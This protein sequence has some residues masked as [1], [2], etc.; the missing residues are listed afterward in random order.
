MQKN[1]YLTAKE[2]HNKMQD[3]STDYFLIDLKKDRED[4][5]N[6]K[7]KELAENWLCIPGIFLNLVMEGKLDQ[8]W[9][10]TESLPEKNILR[11]GLE[12]VHP[13]ITMKR[14]FENLEYLKSIN[15][16]LSNV[17]LTCTRPSLLNGLND[18]SRIGPF[19]NRKKD[20]FLE[21][22]KY[23]YGSDCSIF[24]H[25]LCLAE[26]NYQQNNLVEAELL[27]S[28]TIK[29]FDKKSK[30]R[31]LFAALFLQSKIMLASNPHIKTES[32]IQNIENNIKK[33]GKR[34]FYY[35]LDAVKTLFSMYGG[36]QKFIFDWLKN[37]SP[38]EYSDFNMLDL[39]R[40]MIK[41]RCYIIC[42]N[43][44]AAMALADKLKDL[45]IRGKRFMDLCEL[46]LLLAMSLHAAK[47]TELAF[48]TLEEA[49]KLAKRHKYY[50]M[51]ADE[52]ERML[53]L[54]L[55]YI[56]ENG[57]TPFLKYII[58]LTRNMAIQHPLYL[59]ERSSRTAKFSETEI[60][61][62]KLLEQGKNKEEIS[63]YFMISVNTVKY[64]LKKIYAKLNAKYPHQAVWNAK[65]S[66]II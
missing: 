14:L 5:Y 55:A 49:L 7:N 42:G 34:E 60:N 27:V 38:D 19:L 46:N 31:L 64:H 3:F 4:F 62:L 58:E 18:F 21:Y 61:I 26:Y 56:K 9:K 36:D 13:E 32:Y 47:K 40:Y 65:N 29:E 51:I 66:G 22:G 12:I 2:L 35:N 1:K 39:Y 52:G 23:L 25:K 50:R 20:L 24:I 41:M 28:Q 10:L 54:L 33:Q 45:L 6:V 11:I 53:L 57:S 43:T 17:I 16:P 37:N 15:T 8:A 63:E 48:K 59:K 30:I 44:T